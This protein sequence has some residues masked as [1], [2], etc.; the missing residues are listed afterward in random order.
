MLHADSFE[1]PAQLR[2]SRHA[3]AFVS[4]IT[5]KRHYLSTNKNPPRDLSQQIRI[6]YDASMKCGVAQLTKHV[7]YGSTCIEGQV[8]PQSRMTDGCEFDDWHIAGTRPTGPSIVGRLLLCRQAVSSFL[9][10]IAGSTAIHHGSILSDN[11]ASPVS[12]SPLPMNARA[13]T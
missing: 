3:P 10:V 6:V 2:R 7:S 9:P 12:R 1:E 4:S 11:I 8:G 5:F 13:F